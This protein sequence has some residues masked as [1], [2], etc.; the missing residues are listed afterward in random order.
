VALLWQGKKFL[1]EGK[2]RQKHGVSVRM[3]SSYA[4]FMEIKRERGVAPRS[5]DFLLQLGIFYV[6]NQLRQAHGACFVVSAFQPPPRP[7]D[8]RSRGGGIFG[9]GFWVPVFLHRTSF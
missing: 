6:P 1:V 2:N 4:Q 3:Y 9:T 7:A 8:K 5:L